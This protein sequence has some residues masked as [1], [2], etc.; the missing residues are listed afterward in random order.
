MRAARDTLLVFVLTA[1]AVAGAVAAVVAVR[2]LQ[3]PDVPAGAQDRGVDDLLSQFEQLHKDRE[4]A[5]DQLRRGG[6]AN[7][8]GASGAG[9]R[10]PAAAPQYP[11]D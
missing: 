7:G 5:T 6:A 4:A 11:A 10:S 2:E 9:I 1:A 3:K 8:A